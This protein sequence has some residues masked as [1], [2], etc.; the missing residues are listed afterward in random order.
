MDIDEES[1]TSLKLRSNFRFRRTFS[2]IFLLFAAVVTLNAYAAEP[3]TLD[4]VWDQRGARFFGPLL[5]IL[6]LFG[7]VAS[8][9]SYIL[10]DRD[11]DL[12][13][14]ETHGI[15]R[16]TT[17]QLKLSDI[18]GI[19]TSGLPGTLGLALID[20]NGKEHLLPELRLLPGGFWFHQDERRIKSFIKRGVRDTPRP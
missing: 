3:T 18:T 2:V 4:Q 5:V 19:R 20:Q 14:L 6:G 7:L 9:S 15:W 13:I 1:H 10:L 17:K 11:A 16:D 8:K 12:V